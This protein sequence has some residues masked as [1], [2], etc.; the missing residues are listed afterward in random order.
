M[1]VRENPKQGKL[2][3]NIDGASTKNPGKEGCG[4]IVRNEN[5]EVFIAFSKNLGECTNNYVEMSALKI[6][7]LICYQMGIT[8]IQVEID[9]LSYKNGFHEQNLYGLYGIYGLK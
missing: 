1:V 3:L 6:G 9:S 7:L 5:S 4:G 8:K 2:K